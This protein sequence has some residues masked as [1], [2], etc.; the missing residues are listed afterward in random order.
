VNRHPTRAQPDHQHASQAMPMNTRKLLEKY[1]YEFFI[2]TEE[3]RR[4]L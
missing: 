3:K 1:E 2:N 4:T